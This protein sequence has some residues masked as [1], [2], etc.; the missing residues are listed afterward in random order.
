M[1]TYVVC[2]AYDNG[3]EKKSETLGWVIVSDMYILVPFGHTLQAK[4]IMPMFG[5]YKQ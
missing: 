1:G 3:L 2:M 5:S 4:M